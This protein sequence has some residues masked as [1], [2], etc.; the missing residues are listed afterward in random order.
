[1]TKTRPQKSIF[2]LLKL[3]NSIIKIKGGAQM[4]IFHSN[5]LIPLKNELIDIVGDYQGISFDTA[6]V[7]K[8]INQFPLPYHELIL[9]ELISVFK[10]SYCT[11]K[12]FSQFLSDLLYNKEIFPDGFQ[13]HKFINPQNIGYSQKYILT[14]LNDLTLQK[15]NFSLEQ[16]GNATPTSYTYID[17][18]FYSGRRLLNDMI[19]WK[20]TIF[21][22]SEI[23]HINFI[24]Y[25]L[26]K[27]DQQYIFNEIKKNFPNSKIGI[28]AVKTFNNISNDSSEV[29][30]LANGIDYSDNAKS[31]I[32]NIES[33]RSEKQNN[34]YPLLRSP[35]KP[36]IEDYFTSSHNRKIVEQIF[37]ERGIEIISHAA[38]P[39]PY[40]RP[41]GF[42]RIPTL[43]FG[44]YFVNFRNIANN[45]PVVLWWGNPQATF[46]INN[47]YPLFPRTVH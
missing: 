46:G 10:N 4:N 1:M 15:H 22:S 45:C 27:R 25:A 16:C 19:N 28:W 13:N 37:F 44:S 14:F 5:N 3:I 29:F 17:D 6:H 26:H 41:F 24:F 36:L 38:N 34:F 40:M 32:S 2:L 31:Y 8:W 9:S 11:N 7:T 33:R 21:D 47:W 35:N 42:D 18:A 12:I 43:G 20:K 39:N 23:E 30:S